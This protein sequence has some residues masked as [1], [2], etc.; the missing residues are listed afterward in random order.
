[1]RSSTRAIHWWQASLISVSATPED[2]IDTSLS[3]VVNW[4][5]AHGHPT[6][7]NSLLHM[8]S[9][10]SRQFR[11]QTSMVY[12]AALEHLGLYVARRAGGVRETWDLSHRVM[13]PRLLG[14]PCQLSVGLQLAPIA[15]SPMP[16]RC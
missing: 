10:H 15:P 4:L 6:I 11:E 14:D 1:M 12:P 2:G 8:A 9:V 3:E 13:R 5:N 16:F 7:A